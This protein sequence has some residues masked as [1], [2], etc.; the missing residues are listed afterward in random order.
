M[1]STTCSGNKFTRTI[2]FCC[3]GDQEY[4]TGTEATALRVFRGMTCLGNSEKP[5][6]TVHCA[7]Q[8]RNRYSQN[9]FSTPSQRLSPT[10][11]STE[12]RDNPLTSRVPLKEPTDV[13][14]W[15]GWIRLVC[16]SS[17]KMAV[18]AMIFWRLLLNMLWKSRKKFRLTAKNKRQETYQPKCAIIWQKLMFDGSRYLPQ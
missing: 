15:T 11:Q 6:S 3:S 18:R 7:G 4:M 12:N 8:Q 5:L 17:F 16:H 13:M 1:F 2:K 9:T 10:C 14:M